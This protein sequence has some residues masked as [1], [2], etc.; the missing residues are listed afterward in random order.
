MTRLR[1]KQ[2]VAATTIQLNGAY[3]TAV[4]AHS[5]VH[6]STI[7]R[8]YERLQKIGTTNDRRGRA[9][10]ASLK[11]YRYIRLVHLR[12]RHCTP[13]ETTRGCIIIYVPEL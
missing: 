12:D 6:R 8:L 1:Q 4:A 9:R 11:Q 3:Q 13:E 2:R 10:V 7:S 5:K